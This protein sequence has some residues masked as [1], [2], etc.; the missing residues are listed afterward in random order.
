MGIHFVDRVKGIVK[1]KLFQCLLRW[2]LQQRTHVHLIHVH[3]DDPF[4]DM[5]GKL[6]SEDCSKVCNY[7]FCG[8]IYYNII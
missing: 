3:A 8:L 2:L 6:S 4:S 5:T 1:K 7:E